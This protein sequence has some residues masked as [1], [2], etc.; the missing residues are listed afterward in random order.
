MKI[1]HLGV[2]RYANHVS[3]THNKIAQSYMLVV[4]YAIFFYGCPSLKERITYG[5]ERNE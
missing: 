2:V 5:Y 3:A 4:K 1:H